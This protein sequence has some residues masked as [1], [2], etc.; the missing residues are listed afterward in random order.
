MKE[1]V[2]NKRMLT[3]CETVALTEE[4]ISI[5]QN[6]FPTK[7]KDPVSFIVKIIIWK[8]IHVKAL[9]DLGVCINLMSTSLYKS[10]D[11]VVLNLLPLSHS[12]LIDLLLGMRGLYKIC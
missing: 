8:S 10:L 1:I 2:A 7:L 4:C 9:C 12:W 5:I 11:L 3:K 6:K